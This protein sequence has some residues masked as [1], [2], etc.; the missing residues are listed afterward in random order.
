[1]AI[2]P[3]KLINT[4]GQE[5]DG[6]GDSIRAAFDKANFLFRDIDTK[7]SVV[8]GGGVIPGID[9]I[10]SLTNLINTANATGT[11]I[12]NL[13]NA[14]NGLISTANSTGTSIAGLTRT[15]NSL[16]NSIS[17]L[18]NSLNSLT[19]RVVKLENAATGT[20]G[21]TNLVT[22]I[23]NNTQSFTQL[24][25]NLTSNFSTTS[26]LSVSSY[27]QVITLINNST[28]SFAQYI[29]NLS[30]SFSTTG[31]LS[32]SSYNQ[33]VTL[34]NNSTSSFAQYI[35]NLA[36]SFSSSGTLSTSSYNQVITLI[37]N[38]TTSIANRI[39]I[40]DAK[41]NTLSTGSGATI[42]Y[43][44]N[45]VASSTGSLA[46]SLQS[47]K[48]DF[49]TPG[50]IT[51]AAY[52]GLTTLI[53]NSTGSFASDITTLKTNYTNLAN[54][55][56]TFGTYTNSIAGAATSSSQAWTIA[57]TVAAQFTQLT[58]GAGASVEYVTNV[59]ASSTAS[60]TTDLTNFKNSFKT[61]GGLAGA[62]FSELTTLVANSTGSIASRVSTLSADYTNLATSVT[63]KANSSDVIALV[64][65]STGSFATRIATL[66]ANSGPTG[67]GY[68][69]VTYVDT[70]ISNSTSSLASS[71]ETIK[72]TVGGHTT[73]IQTNVE[74]INGLKG[75]YGVTINK[76]GA[77]TGFQI[78]SGDVG[79][80][81]FVITADT[82][83]IFNGTT[84]K[85][86]FSI[87]ANGDV[88]LTNN[89]TID[90]NVTANTMNVG[91][92]PAITG[93]GTTTTMTGNGTRIY[94]DGAFVIGTPSTNIS[95]SPN[96]P[97]NK[98]FING[99]VIFTGNIKNGAVTSYGNITTNSKQYMR[100]P[101]YDRS[102]SQAASI[103]VSSYTF[104]AAGTGFV[105]INWGVW[106]RGTIGVYGSLG[107]GVVLE[108]YRNSSLLASMGYD[109]P[110]S[111]AQGIN[112]AVLPTIDSPG[113]TR[114][115]DFYVDTPGAGNTVYS[116]KA[117]LATPDINLIGGNH[118]YGQRLD[119]VDYY[120]PVWGLDDA[121]A[122]YVL[123]PFNEYFG[124]D[125]SSTYIAY[126][127]KSY[128]NVVEFKK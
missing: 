57:Q 84:S 26:S 11:S 64:T 76:D 27:N 24:V 90:G 39:E 43:V 101:V 82:F 21:Y 104:D 97:Y 121:A 103:N 32:T 45:A 96:A 51:G 9:Y 80:S 128:L 127:S 119:G 33:V 110:V 92:N 95:Y 65:N 86:P 106:A 78:N 69:S 125:V 91:S 35:Q 42:S 53:S 83:K 73:S 81:S 118:L 55:V 50:R 89:I 66:E 5:N 67:G 37:N 38:S 126:V 77:I 85:T 63:N 88:H 12:R 72:S 111:T 19:N 31:T 75:K 22:I 109:G 79:A 20:S 100:I 56:T 113:P 124:F 4:G 13:T 44:D 116:I 46:S 6:T 117:R 107:I 41:F 17:S 40:L 30:S 62:G 71:V 18:T 54:S 59:V 115:T 52:T 10:S 3:R 15:T 70:A 8:A 25:Q 102:N 14:V 123:Y 48:T 1:M 7:I 112:P 120:V 74:S 34:I 105:Q 98:M 60:I 122:T 114:Y 29:Q 108:L 36:S 49:S 28:S 68:A 61:P 94:A 47:L 23:N 58:T 2:D 87:D 93:D 16:T 99:E